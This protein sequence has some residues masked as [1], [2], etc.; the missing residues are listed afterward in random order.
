M[1]VDSRRNTVFIIGALMLIGIISGSLYFAGLDSSVS[2]FDSITGNVVFSPA[3]KTFTHMDTFPQLSNDYLQTGGLDFRV[4]APTNTLVANTT[5]TG[6]GPTVAV[7]TMMHNATGL[8]STSLSADVNITNDTLVGTNATSIILELNDADDDV[9][10]V[11]CGLYYNET[12]FFMIMGNTTS[13]NE[14]FSVPTNNGTL[15]VSIGIGAATTNCSFKYS[16]GSVSNEWDYIVGSPNMNV[17]LISD[18][19]EA[20]DMWNEF[21][22]LNWMY[23]VS[24][25][26]TLRNSFNEKF[27]DAW[28]N[29]MVYRVGTAPPLAPGV[30]EGSE[31]VM[32]GTG[33]AGGSA[34]KAS[35]ASKAIM[36]RCIFR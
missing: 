27:S 3:S 17:K 36:L 25:V 22:N 2:S 35:E 28:L 9:S 10:I 31:F 30:I 13:P 23:T 29:T 5:A 4:D 20:G 16:G 11:D 7:L 19:N 1:V 32:S 8:T 6:P 33:D 15:N 12:G 26:E 18:I 14:F 21:K 34:A 24:T